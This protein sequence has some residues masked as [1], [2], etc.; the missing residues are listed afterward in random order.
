MRPLS[1]EE[2]LACWEASRPQHDLD[3]ALT[4]L[5]AADP[6]LSRDELAELP[7]GERDTRLLRLRTAVLGSDAAGYA[8]CPGC[9][10]AVEFSFD[11]AAVTPARTPASRASGAHTLTVAGHRI[12]YR[13]PNS[14][15][16][17]VAA[18]ATDAADGLQRVLARCIISTPD[19]NARQLS[20][21]VVEAL[22][23]AMSEAD[24]QAEITLALDCPGCGQHWDA[25]FDVAAFF[26]NELAAQA[27]RLLREIDVIARAYGW[28]EREILGLSAR[29]RQS[30]LETIG[31]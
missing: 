27:R 1:P 14:R 9:G 24:P 13:L 5:A 18:A 16:L 3:R 15:D 7:L 11:T 26:W 29:R 4:L 23:H 20:P 10:Q 8:A 2:I 22:S 21:A 31:A 28:S 19:A 25:L 6:E 12:R 30:Y 17:A